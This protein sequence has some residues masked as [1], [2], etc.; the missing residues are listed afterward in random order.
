MTRPFVID[1]VTKERREKTDA[2]MAQEAVDRAALDA[3]PT[4]FLIKGFTTEVVGARTFTWCTF[5]AI[6]VNLTEAEVT[7]LTARG[8]DVTQL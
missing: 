3:R 2:E 6:D 1:R 7:E 4:R 5:S 8:Y